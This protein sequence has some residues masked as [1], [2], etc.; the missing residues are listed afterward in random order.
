MTALFTV[1]LPTIELAIAYIPTFEKAGPPFYGRVSITREVRSLAVF[2][3]IAVAAENVLVDLSAIA[4]SRYPNFT[5]STEAF[6]TRPFADMLAAR[7]KF[8]ANLPTAPPVL[9]VRVDTA[10]RGGLLSAEA[11]LSRTHM[12]ARRARPGVTHDRAGMGAFLRQVV[13]P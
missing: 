3:V 10:S 9:I 5:G 12:R 6:V 1:M 13:R 11:A 7:H 4:A 8:S 2:L